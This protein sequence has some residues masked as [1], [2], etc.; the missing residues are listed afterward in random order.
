MKR[1]ATTRR[2]FTLIEV[3]ISLAIFALAAVVLA[4]TYLNVLGSYQAAARR[5]QG[6]EDWKLVRTTVLS[7]PD[8]TKIESGGRLPL[9][10]G[11]NLRWTAKIE[12]AG[13]ADLFAVTIR[14]GPE[15]AAAGA[16]SRAREQKLMLLRPHWS[17]PVARDKLRAAT[18]QRLLGERK[19]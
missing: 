18:Q 16:D 5:Q 17:D 14:A 12:E 3:L 13:V 9:A 19:P 1:R 7:E 11:S 2:A 10:D 6:E 4:A 8:R 15:F